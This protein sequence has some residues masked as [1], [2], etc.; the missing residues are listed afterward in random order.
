LNQAEFSRKWIRRE[1]IW[2][3]A[4]GVRNRHWSA[5][6][7][8]GKAAFKG[9]SGIDIFTKCK[10][11][12]AMKFEWDEEK[13]LANVVKHGVDFTDACRLFDGPFMLM[14]DNRRDYGAIRSIAFGH[15]ES[16]LIAVAFTKRQDIIRIISVRKAND[17]EKKRFKD[18]IAD[19]LETDRF[20]E[21]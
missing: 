20:H 4:E 10:Y 3:C 1:E 16:R 13:R 9:N 19:R 18:A 21:G 7:L 5:G 2:D 17:R 14:T 12:E 11:T 8:S 6:K 15:V